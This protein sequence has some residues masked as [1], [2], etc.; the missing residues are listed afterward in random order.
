LPPPRGLINRWPPPKLSQPPWPHLIFYYKIPVTPGTVRVFYKPVL[1]TQRLSIKLRIIVVFGKLSSL[2]RFLI[3]L[4]QQ[5]QTEDNN[6]T[7]NII[8]FSTSSRPALGSTQPPIPWILGVL[9]PGV[10]RPGRE[11]D[12]SP[13]A[14]TEVK[15][16]WIYT[17]TPPQV[18]MA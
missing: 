16:T 4:I 8:T 9:S 15:K 12:H 6:N 17:S 14:S 10:K 2:D 3:Y 18:F 13:P 11:A 1:Y 5:E 7:W